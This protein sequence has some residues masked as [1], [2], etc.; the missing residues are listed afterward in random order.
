MDYTKYIVSLGLLL[1]VAVIYDKYK[2]HAE[3]DEEM[4]QYQLVRKYLVSDSSLAN[5]KLPIMWIYVD[6]HVNARD[7]P[8]F[9]SRNTIDLNQDYMFLTI[10]T[11]ID[12]CGGSFNICLIDDNTFPN[13][14][15]GWNIDLTRVADPIRSKLVDLAMARLLKY[16]GG[17]IVPPSFIC[18]QNLAKVFYGVT[19]TY[20]QPIVGE[21]VNT[22]VTSENRQFMVSNKLFGAQ[23]ESPVIDEYIGYLENMISSDY[24][25]ESVFEGSQD[26]WLENAVREGKITKIDAAALGQEDMDGKAVVIDR[27]FGNSYIDLSPTRLGIYIPSERLLKRTDYQS[28]AYLTAQEAMGSDTFVGKLLLCKCSK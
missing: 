10:K 25:A 19:G 18:E 24:T 8:S 21:L 4:R 16:Y 17:L 9:Y 20:N 1:A 27:L 26:R 11:I 14:I 2:M 28:F 22:N 7:W 13:I 3:E 5:A 12:K 6:Y 23:K 15:P